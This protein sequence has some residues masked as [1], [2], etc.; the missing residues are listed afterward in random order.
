MACIP[1]MC[2]CYNNQLDSDKGKSQHGT[3]FDS[4]KE[5]ASSTGREIHT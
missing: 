2:I 3:T 4:S 1:N 5:H